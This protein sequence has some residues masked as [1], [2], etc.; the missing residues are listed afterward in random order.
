MDTPSPA[1]RHPMLLKVLSVTVALGFL[2]M[3]MCTAGGGGPGA[4]PTQAARPAT[5]D[6]GSADSGPPAA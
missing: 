5:S 4:P 3:V 6:G 2:G 1:R